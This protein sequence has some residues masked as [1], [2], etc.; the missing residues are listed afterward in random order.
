M[1]HRFST[2]RR[3]RE[4]ILRQ[5]GYPFRYQSWQEVPIALRVRILERI[6]EAIE[7]VIVIR[8]TRQ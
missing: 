2:S 8:G 4:S 7:E 6:A 3:L 1:S 5:A